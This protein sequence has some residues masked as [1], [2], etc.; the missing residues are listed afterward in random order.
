MFEQVA[1]IGPGPLE[2]DYV[3]GK[4]I[5]CVLLVEGLFTAKVEKNAY[6]CESSAENNCAYKLF[7][8]VSHSVNYIYDRLNNPINFCFFGINFM[9]KIN[10]KSIVCRVFCADSTVLIGFNLTYYGF[11]SFI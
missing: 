11:F 4:I 2:S 8:S 3:G 5:S 1:G 9:Q 6:A 10:E 7:C